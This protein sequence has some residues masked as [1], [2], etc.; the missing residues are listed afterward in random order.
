MTWGPWRQMCGRVLAEQV[1]PAGVT[2]TLSGQEEERAEALS[3]LLMA[4]A[5]A[6]FL[7][8]LVMASQFES[9][10]HPFVIIFTLPLGAIGVIGGSGSDRSQH[11]HRR[12]DRRG[13]AGRD[14]RQQ[15]HRPGGCGQPDGDDRAGSYRGADRR[16]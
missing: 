7:V 13:D 14:C 8:Y 1:Y 4:M 11:Q 16:R 12:H 10:L 3:S 2:A 15:C 9:F 5:L 6:I